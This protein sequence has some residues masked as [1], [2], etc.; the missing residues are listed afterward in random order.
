MFCLLTQQPTRGGDLNNMPSGLALE[1]RGGR[2]RRSDFYSPSF[3]GAA[4][5]FGLAVTQQSTRGGAAISTI[6]AL[7]QG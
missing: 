4:V 1:Q 7:G 5:T 6:Y 2:R 3:D